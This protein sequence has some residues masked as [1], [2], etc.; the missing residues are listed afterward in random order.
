M[1]FTCQSLGSDEF[2]A[3]LYR[4]GVALDLALNG[5][6]AALEAEPDIDGDPEEWFETMPLMVALRRWLRS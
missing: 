1:V 3:L 2:R 4:D 5:A 6:R